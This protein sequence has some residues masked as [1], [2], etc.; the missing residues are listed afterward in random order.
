[1]KV[2]LIPLILISFPIN[3]DVLPGIEVIDGDQVVTKFS[4]NKP[5]TLINED[6]VVSN[7]PE[8]DIDKNLKELGIQD[9]KFR[10]RIIKSRE[11]LKEITNAQPPAPT[12]TD[13]IKIIESKNTVII[14]K[15]KLNRPKKRVKRKRKIARSLTGPDSIQVYNTMP[16]GQITKP[17]ET[18]VVPA[19]SMSEGTL[20]A[21]VE[22]SSEKRMVDLRID[23]AFL[24]PNNAVVDLK[25][26][27][28]WV[29]VW[30]NYNNER[31]Y[32]EAKTITCRTSAGNIFTIPITGQIRDQKDEYIG[33]SAKLVARGKIAAAAM[34]FLQNGTKEFG[35]ALAA[36]QVT[37]T[38]DREVSGIGSSL[39]EVE[40]VTGS[41]GKYITG[42]SIEGA[43]G[44]FL[45]WW[46]SYYKS[47]SPTLAVPPGT[48][49]FLSL[50][51]EVKIPSEFFK[52]A[53]NTNTYKTITLSEREK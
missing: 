43:S 34:Q 14:P 9:E 51:D 25:G 8:K 39:D 47:L 36:A 1:M 12:I 6:Q 45:D 29:E 33:L 31:I 10:K 30:G 53:S 21:G 4:R 26:C 52:S 50:K 11:K 28:T 42:K 37:T 49:L 38:R 15:S 17:I 27:K 13:K 46:I 24:G 48:K 20:M 7:L 44:D 35:K 23:Y 2:S 16:S 41:R 3:A 40:N 19:T 32:G 22:V 18:M 5:N